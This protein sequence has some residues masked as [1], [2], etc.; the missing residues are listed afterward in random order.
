MKKTPR[1]LATAIASSTQPLPALP[2][3]R[4]TRRKPES[5]SAPRPKPAAIAAR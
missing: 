1:W 3:Q 5:L 4:G 2:F